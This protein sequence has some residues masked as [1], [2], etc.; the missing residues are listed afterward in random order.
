M[1]LLIVMVNRAMVED[2]MD[3]L[4]VTSSV[5]RSVYGGSVSLLEQYPLA[6]LL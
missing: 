3:V 1:R 2:L 5:P 4:H 6:G